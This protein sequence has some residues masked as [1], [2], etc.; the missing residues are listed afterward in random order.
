MTATVEFWTAGAGRPGRVA[1][2]AQRLEDAGWDGWALVDSQNL[3]PDPYVHLG[4]A[5]SAT[6]TLKLATGVTNPLTRHPAAAATAM[7]TVQAESGG[8]AVLGIGRGD[9]SL[10]HLGLAPASLQT[11]ERYLERLQG[12]LRG[13]DVAFDVSADGGKGRP[14]RPSVCISPAAPTPAGFGGSPLQARRS[15]LTWPPPGPR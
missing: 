11:F 9:S 14:T 6:S 15:R 8:R 12:Y 13:E 4:L 2:T 1:Q 5:A 7:A 3:A 10:A